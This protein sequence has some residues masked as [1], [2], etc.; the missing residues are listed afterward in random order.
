MSI[1]IV[2]HKDYSFPDDDFYSPIQVGK[3]FSDYILRDNTLDNISSKN[4]NY[5]ELTALYWLWKNRHDDIIGLVH[6]RRY[7]SSLNEDG[8]NF[9]GVNI[10]RK[11]YIKNI[12][13]EYDL[14]LPSKIKFKVPMFQQWG[15]AHSVEDWINIGKVIKN[16]YPDYLKSYYKISYS[17]E[18]FLYNMFI[19]NKSLVNSYC[20]WLFDILSQYEMEFDVEK[21]DNYQSR[22]YGFLSERLFN[23]WV[24]NNHVVIKNLDVCNLEVEHPVKKKF[25]S[26]LMTEVINRTK[27]CYSLLRFKFFSL[28]N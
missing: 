12:L 23:I 15:R 18:L 7:F 3:G 28:T 6:Y 2:S 5:C 14:I 20:S 24:D 26:K 8:I 21:G 13:N 19:G 1:Y 27:D 17:K 4:K 22:L 25:I 11:E 16:K 9:N 10:P